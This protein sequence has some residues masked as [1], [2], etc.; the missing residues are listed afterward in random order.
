M[1][2]EIWNNLYNKALSVCNGHDISDSIFAGSVA[3]AILTD[4]G[5]IYYLGV[6]VDTNCS[7][8]FCAERNAIGTMLTFENPKVIKVV[9]VRQYGEIVM[10]CGA[11]REL[12]MQLNGNHK[13]QILENRSPLRIVILTGLMPNYWK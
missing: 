13:T 5:T 10:P 2:N 6:S 1:S 3:S 7:L 12:L 11:C 9:T 8:G 4:K